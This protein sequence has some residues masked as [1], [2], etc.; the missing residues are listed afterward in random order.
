MV[1]SCTV[2]DYVIECDCY[3]FTYYYNSIMT[4]F[5]Q[6]RHATVPRVC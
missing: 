2:G 3:A 5:W 1:A 4:F 6:P